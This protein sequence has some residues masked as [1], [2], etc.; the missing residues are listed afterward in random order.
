MSQER[1]L[2]SAITAVAAI[3]ILAVVS[4]GGMM[5]GMMGPSMTGTPYEH[6]SS[7]LSDGWA[8]PAMMGAGWLMMLAFLAIIGIALFMLLRVAVGRPSTAGQDLDARE[9]LRRRYAAGEIDEATYEH[10]RQKLAA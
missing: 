9:I 5:G 2:W 6:M 7:P 10:Q 1:G 4:V 8:W 3:A